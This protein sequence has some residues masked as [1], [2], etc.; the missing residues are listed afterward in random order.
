[1]KGMRPKRNIDTVMDAVTEM[2]S[3]HVLGEVN[4]YD[5]KV[6]NV[7]GSYVEHVH[8]DTDEIF[9]VLAGRLTLDLPDG[10]VVL[11]PMDVCTVPRGVPHRPSAEPG[12]RVLM[13]EP[14]GTAQDGAD[15]STGVRA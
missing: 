10:P 2:W 6:A 11:D 4:D 14:R 13:V 1:M 12:T 9:V 8:E 7:A 15:G 5:V 3:P